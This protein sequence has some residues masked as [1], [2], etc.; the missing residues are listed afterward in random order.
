MLVRLV[1]RKTVTV[2]HGI[3][4]TEGIKIHKKLFLHLLRFNRVSIDWRKIT[5]RIGRKRCGENV[6]IKVP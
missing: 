3:G 4:K 6:V 1:Q 5:K 2:R